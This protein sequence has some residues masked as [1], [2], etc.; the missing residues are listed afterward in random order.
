VREQ[1]EVELEWEVV[2][3]IRCAIGN[4]VD[5]AGCR[6]SLIPNPYSLAYSV[7]RLTLRLTGLGVKDYLYSSFL[8]FKLVDR[9]PDRLM[10]KLNNHDHN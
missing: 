10:I 3:A 8:M 1:R 4:G 9:I 2:E 5:G 7:V 6:K